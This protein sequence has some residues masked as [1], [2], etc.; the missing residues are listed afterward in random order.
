[1][2]H[3]D[4][5]PKLANNIRLQQKEAKTISLHKLAVLHN[6]SDLHFTWNSYSNFEPH[7]Y[8]AWLH[9]QIKYEYGL[10]K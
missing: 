10:T 2:E 9:L 4:P 8:Y 7:L 3:K 5:T 6:N 1:M